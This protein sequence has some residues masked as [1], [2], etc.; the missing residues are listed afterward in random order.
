M[1]SGIKGALVLAAGYSRRFGGGKLS[2]VLD[3]GNTVLQ[4][5][6][7]RIGAATEHILVVTRQELIDDGLLDTGIC[8]ASPIR[9]GSSSATSPQGP[10]LRVAVCEDAH[11]G[12][13]HTLAFGVS[14]LLSLQGEEAWDG[15]LVCLGDMPFISPITYQ[16]LLAELQVDNIV[17]PEARGRSANPVGFGRDFFP[18]LSRITGD[19]GGRELIRRSTSQVVRIPVSDTAVLQDVDTPEDLRR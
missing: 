15:C 9:P 11:L 1:T 2:A 19:G 17:V 10:A 8:H 5:T 18:D 3:S 4:Q 14:Q 13:G 7:Q 16:Q 12:M 6:L